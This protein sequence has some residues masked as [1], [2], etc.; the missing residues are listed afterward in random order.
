MVSGASYVQIAFADLISGK[1]TQLHRGNHVVTVTGE[2]GLAALLH[3]W[4]DMMAPRGRTFHF[5]HAR[6]RL[7]SR[8]RDVP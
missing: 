7:S 5:A 6:I 1:V 2:N 4:L 3:I 8:R